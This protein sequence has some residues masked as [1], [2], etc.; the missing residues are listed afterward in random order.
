MPGLR[1]RWLL[2]AVLP[3][4]V[5]LL[6]GLLVFLWITL[7][8]EGPERRGILAVAAGGAVVICGVVLVVLVAFIRRP[9]LELQEKIARLREGDLTATAS[10]AGRN[11]ELGELGRNFNEMV[12]QL[13]ESQEATD[14][15]HRA[16]ISRAEHL[17]TL[18]ELAAGLA[19]EI[20]NPLAGIAGV[21]DVLGR[22]LPE[23]SPSREI[24]QELRHEIEHIQKILSDLLE[25]ARPRPPQMQRGDLNQT[26]EQAV[27]LA[28]QQVLSRPIRIEFVKDPTLP[29]VEHDTAQIQQVLLNLLLNAVQAIEAEGTIEMRLEARGK[30]AVAQV[31]D[32]GRGIDPAHLPNIFR[33]FFTTKGKGTGLGLSLAQRIAEDHG[34]SIEV[35]SAPGQGSCFTLRIPFQKA[36]EMSAVFPVK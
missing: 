5:V 34:G 23:A 17:A 20:R 2:K 32:T 29:P 12:R 33:P 27:R 10:F 8:L 16:E 24:W 22:D 6:G 28:Q 4:A 36:R 13:R 14:R 9:L 11:D 19:H 26:A 15:A 31:S 25:Y 3:V 35:A 21:L 7:S 18:G 1:I 30:F